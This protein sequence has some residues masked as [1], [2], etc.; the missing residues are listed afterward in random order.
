MSIVPMGASPAGALGFT[1]PDGQLLFATNGAIGLENGPT[2]S[3]FQY[4]FPQGISGPAKKF[5]STHGCLSVPA[6]FL[7]FQQVDN[8][9]DI[10]HFLFLSLVD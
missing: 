2:G 1:R 7:G 8:G 5:L 6:R 9:S 10:F 3:G 4:M